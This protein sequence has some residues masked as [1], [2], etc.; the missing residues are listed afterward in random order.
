MHDI[1]GLCI[2]VHSGTNLAQVFVLSMYLNVKFS[3]FE[4]QLLPYRPGIKQKHM[5]EK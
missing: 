5:V 2:W 3:C 4:T 1:A